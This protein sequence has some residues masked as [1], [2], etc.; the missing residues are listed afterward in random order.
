MFPM[1]YNRKYEYTRKVGAGYKSV[2]KDS[3]KLQLITHIVKF[4]TTVM[5]YLG[6]YL[7]ILNLRVTSD[8]KTS[9]A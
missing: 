9:H 5:K 1:R 8:C 2:G 4:Y 3:S 6:F 7:K